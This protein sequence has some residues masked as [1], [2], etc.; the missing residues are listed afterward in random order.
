M[1]WINSMGS[2]FFEVCGRC[3]YV[4]CLAGESFVEVKA[5]GRNGKSRKKLPSPSRWKWKPERDSLTKVIASVMPMHYLAVS[6]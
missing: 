4:V 6:A 2:R 3:Q 1:P 5:M